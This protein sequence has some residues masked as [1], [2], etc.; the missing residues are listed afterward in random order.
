MSDAGKLLATLRKPS[1]FAVRL[2][3]A[4]HIYMSKLYEYLA[5]TSTLREL[6]VPDP[7]G[8][9]WIERWLK[10]LVASAEFMDVNSQYADFYPTFSAWVDQIR[11]SVYPPNRSE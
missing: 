4:G 10:D 8:Q 11:E 3:S 2:L 7:L 6:D 5:F 9:N 1:P